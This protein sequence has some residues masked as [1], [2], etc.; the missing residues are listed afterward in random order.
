MNPRLD[1]ALSALVKTAAIRIGGGGSRRFGP[2]KSFAQ[3]AM[4]SPKITPGAKANIAMGGNLSRMAAPVAQSGGA[5]TG[6][7]M[8]QLFRGLGANLAAGAGGIGRTIMQH[9]RKLLL[10]GAGVP[11]YLGLNRFFGDVEGAMANH[12]NRGTP[13]P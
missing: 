1:T 5:A 6:P 11:A 8:G 3:Q 10:A 13:R 7:G 9:P 4:R 2:P 12:A